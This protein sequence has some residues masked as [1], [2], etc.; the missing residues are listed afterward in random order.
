[1]NQLRIIEGHIHSPYFIFIKQSKRYTDIEILT[2]LGI[3]DFLPT[4]HIKSTDRV[5]H[6]T[7]DGN[8]THVIDDWL[9]TQWHSKSVFNHIEKLAKKHDIFTCSVG[10]SDSSYDFHYFK[11]GKL[12]RRYIYDDPKFDGGFVS[13]DY[14]IPIRGE[15]KALQKCDELNKVLSVAQLVG[16]EIKHQASQIRS[17]SKPYSK[18]SW[19]QKI[20]K[21][22]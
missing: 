15:E 11:N 17:F 14:G 19:L 2:L 12:V 1:M 22:I 18:P 5:V 8:W 16:I 21:K 9:Y 13:E 10:D 6:I 3:K 20:F 7:D 4:T